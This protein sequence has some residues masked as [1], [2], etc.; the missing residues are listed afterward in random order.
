MPFYSILCDGPSADTGAQDPDEP[1]F[2]ADLALD[3]I[4]DA[5]VVG[6]EEYGLRPLFYAPRRDADTVGYR[7]DVMRDLASDGPREAIAAFSRDMQAVRRA[8]AGAEQNAEDLHKE[9]RLLDAAD[10]YCRAVASLRA[11]LAPAALASRGLLGFRQYLEEY[12]T[13]AAFI[14]LVAETQAQCEALAVVR[15]NLHLDAGQVTVSR[16]G[17]ESDYSVEIE[18]AFARFPRAASKRYLTGFR[19]R[20][21]LDA[22]EARIFEAVVRLYPRVFADLDRFCGRNLPFL[23]ECLERFEREVQFYL[24]V[25]EYLEPLQRAGLSFCYPRVSDRPGDEFARGSFDLALAA[26]LNRR[27]DLP[28]CNDFH[29]SGPERVIVVTGPNQGGKTTFARMFGQLHYLAALGC[30]IP[31]REARLLLADQILTHFERQEGAGNQRGRLEDELRRAQEILQ[32]AT[33]HSVVIMNEG[34]TSTTLGDA[35]FIG[36]KVLERVLSLGSLGVYV[37]FVDDLAAL[38]EATVSMVGQVD[39]SDPSLRTYRIIRQP[40]SGMAHAA[41]IADKY[42]LGYERL[43]ERLTS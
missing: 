8:L 43:K 36:T 6:R 26:K 29:L 42:G 12:G 19:D 4:V 1:A 24:A 31:G 14:S 27:A 18:E 2:F 32:R 33:A 15:Y 21:N 13:S 39:P 25:L 11:G 30:P 22:V 16:Y 28:V 40:A 34:F 10:V 20:P 38:G 35:R 41:A 7:Q 17:G 9:R 5:L 3:R 23:D 37:T